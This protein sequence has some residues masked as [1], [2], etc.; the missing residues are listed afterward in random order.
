M[1]SFYTFFLIPFLILPVIYSCSASDGVLQSSEK[2]FVVYPNRPSP[3]HSGM[4]L[5][6]LISDDVYSS[7]A[8]LGLNLSHEFIY[9]SH[10]PSL[11]QAIV[12]I[13]IGTDGGGTGSFVSPNGLI[14]T[15]HHVVYDGIAAVSDVESNFLKNGFYAQEA[16]DEIPIPGYSIYI[17]IEQ[18]EVTDLIH[19]RLPD[20][21]SNRQRD[22]IK[23]EIEQELIE[24]RRAG[25]DDLVVEIGDYWSDNRQFMVVYQVIRDVRLVYAPEEAIG[26]FGGDI[27]N[28]MWPRHTGDFAFLRAYLSADGTAEEYQPS[29]VPF[30]PDYFLPFRSGDLYPGDFTM[31]LGFPGTTYRFESSY[32]FDFYEKQQFPALHKMFRAYLKGLE[33]ESEMDD[34]AAVQD[35]GERASIANALKYYEG[36]RSGFEKYNIT[37]KKRTQDREFRE[38][39][40]ADSLREITYGQVLPQLEQSYKIAGQMGD[41][42]FMSFYAI[43]Y[44]SLLQMGSFFNDFYEYSLAPDSLYFSSDD[45]QQLYDMVRMWNTTINLESELLILSEMLQAMAEMPEERRP[46]ILYQLFESSEEE[47]LKEEIRHF[48]DRQATTSA[49]TDTSIAA[50]WIYT[51]MIHSEEVFQDSLYLISRDLFE[52]FEQSRDNYFQHFQYLEPAQR[53]Y[54]QGMM[55][56]QN[57]PN[58]YPDA[59]FTLRLSAGQIM[60]YRPTDG[61]YNT[62][63]TTFSGLVDK[64]TGENPFTVPS[65]LLNYR[66]DISSNHIPFGPYSQSGDLVLNFLSS[67]DITGGNSGSPV[68]NGDGEII[69]LAFDGNIEG[70]V[71]DYYFIP[72]VTRMISVDA[73][74]ILFMMDEID[75]TERLLDEIE[76]RRE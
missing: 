26:K 64:H 15:N 66:Q 45:R 27:D 22:E 52:T 28:W 35:A 50:K 73:R 71:S 9:N 49:L 17:P 58:Q 51:E 25:N 33:L 47:L 41:A 65:K 60:G 11:N 54:V 3:D 16:N 61:V 39:V 57:R 56:M 48:V 8:E 2:E 70:I 12:R 74:Y 30:E 59:N 4:W 36:V 43:Q 34:Q 18:T 68:L 23:N 53:L 69:G 76:L 75:Q 13:N 67:N 37:Q 63:F 32:A 6:P 19:E 40:R 31:T 10:N 42:L 7:L 62:P 1:R 46:L 20:G 14:L 72:D 5:L 44:S 24:E 55:E 29:N 38:W 21:L